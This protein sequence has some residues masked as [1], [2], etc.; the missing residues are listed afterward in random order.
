MKLR[1]FFE[2]YVSRFLSLLDFL[3]WQYDAIFKLLDPLSHILTLVLA[4]YV[5]INNRHITLAPSVLWKQLVFHFLVK[6]LLLSLL[7]LN[8][9]TTSLRHWLVVIAHVIWILIR[10]GSCVVLWRSVV[11]GWSSCLG[12]RTRWSQ[13]I[14]RAGTFAPVWCH[15]CIL[16]NRR[17]HLLLIYIRHP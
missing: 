11:E 16:R 2:S 13:L 7:L 3:Q 8:D 14:C 15:P 17:F 10:L 4:L 5:E 9:G 12:L 1:S 6:I